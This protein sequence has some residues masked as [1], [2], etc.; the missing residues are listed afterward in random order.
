MRQYRGWSNGFFAEQLV[1]AEERADSAVWEQR[2]LYYRGRVQGVGF[3]YTTQG[4][5]ARFH[6]TGYVQ[7]LADGRVLLVAEG[8]PQELDRFV[9]SVESAL[10]H[11][12]SGV[13]CSVHAATRQFD[14]F[15]IQR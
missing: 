6:L 11:Y 15:R 10:E 8:S 14:G 12:I 7:N 5:A 3:R 2:M 1:L 13:E 9:Q 4:I